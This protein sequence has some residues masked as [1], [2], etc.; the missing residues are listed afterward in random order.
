MK[1]LATAFVL[2]TLAATPALAK[3]DH[4]RKPVAAQATDSY[5]VSES[6]YG[7]YASAGAIGYG[8]NSIYS[9]GSIATTNRNDVVFD[10]LVIGSDPDPN[11][12]FQ[13]WREAPSLQGGPE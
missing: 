5:L 4:P 6:G 8:S 9:D 10:G 1:K 7:S 12:R 11:I 2:A 13:L 3:T